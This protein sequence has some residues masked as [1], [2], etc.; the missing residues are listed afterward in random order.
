MIF[1]VDMK[2]DL[3]IFTFAIT[4]CIQR[5]ELCPNPDMFSTSKDPIVQQFISG[6]ATGPLVTP[7]F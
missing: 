6:T 2:S 3:Y 5:L 1:Y 4:Q 7:G